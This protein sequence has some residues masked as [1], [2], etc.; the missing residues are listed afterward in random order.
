MSTTLERIMSRFP[1]NSFGDSGI[2]HLRPGQATVNSDFS[3]SPYHYRVIADR[4]ISPFPHSPT[5]DV[6]EED[7]PKY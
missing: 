4:E 1:I 6:Y 3:G 5:W 2:D 7:I